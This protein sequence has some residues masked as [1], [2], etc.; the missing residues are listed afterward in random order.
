MRS[1]G[2]SAASSPLVPCQ[3]PL[4]T[5]RDSRLAQTAL[6]EGRA[7]KNM[8]R[9][10]LCK[11]TKSTD[12]SPDRAVKAT[13][14]IRRMQTRKSMKECHRAGEGRGAAGA[15][16]SSRLCPRP[17]TLRVVLPGSR[18]LPSQSKTQTNSVLSIRLRLRRPRLHRLR[19]HVTVPPQAT[20]C[21]QQVTCECAPCSVG[22]RALCS[23]RTLPMIGAL[24]LQLM[25][26][27][28]L[29]F[30]PRLRSSR[31]QDGRT[32]TQHCVCKDTA[33]TRGD[34]Y[35]ARASAA[36]QQPCRRPI[37]CVTA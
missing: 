22:D 30:I 19:R 1:A 13:E 14:E 3:M 11:D 9:R 5:V 31:A 29:S 24:G 2:A 17:V 12:N 25:H 18:A 33:I 20:L 16:R 32:P 7:R 26:S 27:T 8:T 21:R 23:P 36:A 35:T 34:G 15:K 28:I 4:I 10:K 6:N 37:Q